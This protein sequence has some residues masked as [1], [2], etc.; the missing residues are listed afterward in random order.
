VFRCCGT[1][2]IVAPMT[3]PL[4]AIIFFI[5]KLQGKLVEYRACYLCFLQL[6]EGIPNQK[7]SKAP[8]GTWINEKYPKPIDRKT[9]KEILV[10]K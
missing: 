10:L 7:K 5:L 9:Y 4:G 2:V 3:L 6:L 1:P 8:F